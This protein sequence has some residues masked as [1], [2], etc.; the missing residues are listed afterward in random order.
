VFWVRDSAK[1]S[2]WQNDARTI[3]HRTARVSGRLE[4][5]DKS[6]RKLGP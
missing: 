5:V 1:A 6:D 2:P 3:L 4:V